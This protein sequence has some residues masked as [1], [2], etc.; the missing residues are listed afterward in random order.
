MALLSVLEQPV[1]PARALASTA[2][3]ADALQRQIEAVRSA[4]AAL[5]EG[6]RS[7][8]EWPLRVAGDYLRGL[9][10]ALL[11]WAWLRMAQV[12]AR[13]AG[14]PWYDDKLAV[15]RFGVQWLLPEASLCWQRVG[16]REAALPPVRVGVVHP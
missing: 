16:A 8:A 5:V 2:P 1:A 9:G 12:A 6:S 4:T 7:D 14:E 11:A 15:A 13:Q 10:F 3:L